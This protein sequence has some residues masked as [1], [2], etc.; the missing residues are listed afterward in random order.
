MTAKIQTRWV[1]MKN[2]DTGYQGYLA[3]PPAGKGPGIVLYQEIFGVNGHI[4]GVA[5]QYAQD[6]FVVLAPDMFWRGAQKV[7]LGYEGAD[8]ERALELMKSLKPEEIQ[9]DVKAA[10]ATLRA[11]PEVAGQKVGAVGYCLGGRL[12]YFSA[13]L[14]DV[15]AAVSYYGG[16]I[17]DN[18]QVVDKIKVPMQ[19]HYAEND[20]AIPLEAVEKVKAAFGDRAEFFVYP[21]A[22]H[23]FNCWD[24]ASYHPRSAALAHGRTLEFFA[25]NLYAQ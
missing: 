6:G 18:L 20:H 13:A 15:N 4:R 21:G 7:E 24:R 10:V 19:F 11:L 3:L 25:Q 1:A 22:Q 12:A 2:S 23:G 17:Q 14:T 9:A 16:G 5:E 8:R